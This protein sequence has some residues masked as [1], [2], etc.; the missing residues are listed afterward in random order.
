MAVV[1][2]LFSSASAAAPPLAPEAD[3]Q[4]GAALG[5]YLTSAGVIGELIASYC[6]EVKFKALKTGLAALE[7]E[8]AYVSA[9]E[10]KEVERY[11][12]SDGYRSAV[13]DTA[14]AYSAS[15]TAGVEDGMDRKTS[16]GLAVGIYIGAAK[17][18]KNRWDSLKQMSR[19]AK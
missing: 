6:P 11:L 12:A 16:C 3:K 13:R 15:I 5:A 8:R 9:A 14:Q 1:L 2:A 17:T 10:F 7:Q 19:P 4:R 18:Q